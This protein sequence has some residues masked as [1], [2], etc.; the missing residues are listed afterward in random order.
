MTAIA[1]CRRALRGILCSTSLALAS[2]APQFAMLIV[3]QDA[4]APT[5]PTRPVRLMVGAPAGG[6]TDIVA[7]M[8]GEN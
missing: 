2:L 5:Y 6:G 8:L 4:A 1:A 7:R 3:A